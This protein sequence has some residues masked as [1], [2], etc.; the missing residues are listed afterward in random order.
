M[1]MF[2]KAVAW[3]TFLAMVIP[4]AAAAADNP[5]GAL[6]AK[7]ADPVGLVQSVDGALPLAAGG[8][9][10]LSTI[11][12]QAQVSETLEPGQTD[13]LYLEVESKTINQPFEFKPTIVSDPVNFVGAPVGVGVRIAN[14]AQDSYHW[15]ARGRNKANLVS[16]W[17]SFGQNIDSPL[18][19]AIDFVVNFPPQAPSA[20]KAKA[21]GNAVVSLAWVN[22]T[23]SDLKGVQIWRSTALDQVGVLA[24]FINSPLVSFADSG[25]VEGTV[26]YYRLRS[27]DTFD[28][29]SAYSDIAAAVTD[30]VIDNLDGAG[31][32]IQ[33]G[34]VVVGTVWSA[35]AGSGASIS[36]TPVIATPGVY[37]V[38]VN[39]L[40]NPTGVALPQA[41][42]AK[43]TVLVNGVATAVTLD[44]TKLA[45]QITKPIAPDTLSGFA[46][47]GIFTLPQGSLTTVR[48]D[49][50]ATGSVNANQANF[51]ILRPVPAGNLQA[52]DHPQDNGGAIDLT[53]D[54]SPS[55]NAVAYNVYR[56]S[57]PGSY[58]FAKPLGTTVE[59]KYTDISAQ[60]DQ[61]YFYVVRA[62][63]RT[64]ESA[65]SNETSVVAKDNQPPAAP[66]IVSVEVGDGFVALT[67]SK[68]D[69]A[70]SYVVGYRDPAKEAMFKT[71]VI[72]GREATSTKI[73]GLANDIEYEFAIAARDAAG[74]QSPFA[75]KR[76]TPN[77]PKQEVK[78]TVVSK[79]KRL[80]APSVKVQ[81]VAPSDKDQEPKAE[82][83]APEQG[84]VKAAETKAG[85]N[86][87]AAT[88]VAI[89]VIAV[90][91]GIAGY[92]GYDWW[93]KRSQEEPEPKRKKN[94]RW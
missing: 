44:Q 1:N 36:Y 29:V 40:G 20:L 27:V 58:D 19:A 5:V 32:V 35:A 56:S 52:A 4:G 81:E 12:L 13:T 15:Q 87:R 83:P 74:N 3:A 38:L 66:S 75:I 46:L 7:P 89:L 93:L 54:K 10:S 59:V 34:G 18:P 31:R 6:S 30:I 33:S 25:L 88:T 28:N 41:T 22:S 42:D 11:V 55:A 60:T 78:Q 50:S 82:Q 63:D 91:A 2:K 51:V 69:D 73:S 80:A 68:V 49:A 61:L 76:A 90:A 57:S 48:L 86:Q 14:I 45:D 85:G 62:T 37:E 53:W 23:D 79:V 24:A 72:E 39:W 43:Y 9:D 8:V 64:L 17:V 84:Q 67:W 77:A 92:Y 65:N 21:Q 71:V 47:L 16:N 70:A 26:Y 94:G